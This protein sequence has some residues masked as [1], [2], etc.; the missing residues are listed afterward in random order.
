[1]RGWQEVALQS[2]ASIDRSAVSASGISAD[3]RYVGMEHVDEDGDVEAAPTVAPGDLRSTKF[4]FSPKHLLY[5]KLRPYLRKIA[6]PSFVGVC[7]TDI[8]PILPGERVDRDYLFHCLRWQP[9]VDLVNAQTT[10][11]NLPRISPTKLGALRIP[12]P[13]LPEQRRIATILDKA[14]AIRRKR[15]ESLA[16][17]DELLRSTFLQMFGDPVRNE[18]G[19]E[20]VR[21]GDV[22]EGAGA[23]VDG[24]FGSSL[25]P[26]SYVPSGVLVVRNFNIRDGHFDESSFK[27]VTN[28]KFAELSRSSVEP[29]DILTSTKGT[30]GR[31]CEMPDLGERAVLSA[32]GTVRVR[33]PSNG[34]AL[35]AFLVDQ[36]ISSPFKRYVRGLE[37]GTNQ[38]YLTLAAI[39]GY[40]MVCPPM[41][42]QA[43]YV[44]CRRLVL[45]QRARQAEALEAATYLFHS[46]S[47]RAFQGEL[48]E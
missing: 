28:E 43:R 8:L 9:L 10:G 29:G 33:L 20:V 24:P 26:E 15:Q 46:L 21:L 25:K 7:S 3:T 34:R 22:A 11:A 36:M 12:L 47:Q 18:R 16:L 39:R 37:A 6:R 35:T 31:V 4:R 2:V 45:S 42:L 1:M 19:W 32:S 23:I 40:R 44:Q 13:P 17:L 27:Y 41:S 38:K 48:S 14:D 5:G 30:L